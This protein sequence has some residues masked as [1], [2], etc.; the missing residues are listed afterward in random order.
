MKMNT[1]IDEILTGVWHNQHNSELHLTV[2]SS[3]RIVGCFI[4]GVMVDGGRSESF[5]LTGFAKGD[6]FAFCADLSKYGCMTSWV[7]QIVDPAS[8][9]FHAM[10]QMVADAQQKSDLAWKSTWVGEDAFEAGPRQS[11]ICKQ[12]LSELHPKYCALV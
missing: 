8:K 4:N 1:P 10:W 7:G 3:G 2:E 5:P 9:R 12:E 6:V 11:E